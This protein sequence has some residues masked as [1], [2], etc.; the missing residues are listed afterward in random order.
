VS[1]G[2]REHLQKLS[3]EMKWTVGRVTLKIPFI[4]G[5]PF[6]F[7]VADCGTFSSATVLV[8][9]TIIL[10]SAHPADPVAVRDKDIVNVCFRYRPQDHGV[11]A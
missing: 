7:H 1:F 4:S 11:E 3:W 2:N 5:I 10:L 8:S 6:D 9:E